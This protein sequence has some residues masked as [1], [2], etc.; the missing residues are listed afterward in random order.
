MKKR[1]LSALLVLCMACSMVST[2]WAEGTNATSGAP[3]P[4]SQT[5]EVDPA[6]VATSENAATPAPGEAETDSVSRPA[7]TE[8]Q[9]VPGTDVTVQVSVPEGALPEDAALTASLIGSSTDDAAAV[10]DVAAELDNAN[11]D[12]DGFVALDISFTD[13]TGAEVEPDPGHPVTVRIELPE[14]IVDSGIDLTTLAVQHLAEDAEGNGDKVEQVASVADG[15]VTLSDAAIAAVNEAAGVAP[16][17]NSALGEDAAEAAVVAEF[18]VDGFSTFTVTWTSNGE[19]ID[20]ICIDSRGRRIGTDDVSFGS[21]DINDTTNLDANFAPKIEGYTFSEARAIEETTILGGEI[22][23]NAVEATQLEYYSWELSNP[24]K[25]SG[26]YYLSDG[27]WTRVTNFDF[28]IGRHVSLY[29]VYT[30]DPV[31]PSEEPETPDPI[32][33]MIS[34]T[35][36]K[37]DDGTYDL[38]LSVTGALASSEKKMPLDVVFVIDESGSMNDPMSNTDKTSRIEAVKDAIGTLTDGISQNENIDVR[39]NVVTFSSMNDTRTRLSWTSDELTNQQAA[40]EVEDALNGMYPNGGTNY[41]AG[42]QQA[43]ENLLGVRQGATTCV[44]FLTDGAPTFRIWDGYE[45]GNGSDDDDGL[46]I[47]GAVQEAAYLN[48][49][50]FYCVGVGSEFSDTNSQAVENLKAIAGNAN[51]GTSDWANAA[52]TKSLQEE[53]AKMTSTLT[54]ITVKDVTISDT[55]SDYVTAVA[56]AQPVIHVIDGDGND[57]TETEVSAGGIS[58]TLSGKELKLDFNDSYELKENY[59][60]TVTLN[61]KP[62]DTA[63]EAYRDNGYSYPDAGTGTGE[64][65]TGTHVGETG[66]FSNDEAT[67]TYTCLNTI[68]GEIVESDPQ[69]RDYPM[70]VVQVN[71]TSLT[72]RKMFAGSWNDMNDAQKAAAVSG[73]SFTVKDGE[74]IIKDNIELVVNSDGTYSATVDGLTIG[75]TYTVT[76]TA[77]APDGYSVTVDTATKT[78]DTLVATPAS[79]TVTFTNTY[80]PATSSLTITKLVDGDDN[81]AGNFD[82]TVTGPAE[83]ANQVLKDSEGKDV[84]FD[85]NATATVTLGDEESITIMGLPRGETY[86]VQEAESSQGDIDLDGETTAKK[87]YYLAETKYQIDSEAATQEKVEVVLTNNKKVTI[88]NT[89]KP[90]KTLTVE[91]IVTGEMGSSSD[92]FDFSATKLD[93]D[94]ASQVDVTLVGEEAASDPT[95]YDFKLKSGSTVTIVNL[96]EGD[97]VTISEAANDNRGYTAQE[98]TFTGLSAGVETERQSN[99]S[100]KVT[101]P[102]GDGTDLGKVTFNN[103]REAVAPTGLESNH[104]TPYVLMITAAGM[105]GLALIGGIVARRIRRRR[106]E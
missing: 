49:N 80:E 84:K 96:K 60:Y 74:T 6:E 91:K 12:Y 68:G 94:G 38:T 24:L 88:T 17:A 95:N 53:F 99:T 67:L 5:V 101:V 75:K 37:Q 87:D 57:V 21:K 31:D 55:L 103:H 56:G 85:A 104:T 54:T 102:G 69:T 1:V 9:T 2:V 36:E 18:E 40:Q 15:T 105:A 66:F 23:Y 20:L 44:I 73:I 34:K 41:Q 90:Y 32:S 63:K 25:L 92:Y 89:Y 58:A 78:T 52:D 16:M 62:S 76:E 22:G 81:K 47:D 19:T 97:E 61:I 51:A 77:T 83:L 46:N 100:V 11:V 26:W 65:G 4:A 93:E 33:P 70:P 82:I 3:E 13:E 86:T 48:S 8:E 30:K 28:I 106:Q 72:I 59:T 29:L 98:P 35:A 79:N 7:R 50:L 43:E 71:E 64:A 42:L 14:T 45:V 39:Y 10:A 27:E